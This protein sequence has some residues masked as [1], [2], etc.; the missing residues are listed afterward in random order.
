MLA[1]DNAQTD[2]HLQQHL[3]LHEHLVFGSHVREVL[4]ARAEIRLT[5]PDCHLLQM[6]DAK[7]AQLAAEL[8]PSPWAA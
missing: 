1:N 6:A 7:L 3:L 8:A 4:A 2:L 5:D